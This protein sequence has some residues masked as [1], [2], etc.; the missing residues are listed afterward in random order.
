VNALLLARKIALQNLKRPVTLGLLVGAPLLL[1][2]ILGTAL[3]DVWAADTATLTVDLAYLESGD[4]TLDDAFEAFVRSVSMINAAE[5]DTQETGVRAVEAA[6]YDSL[7]ILD[8]GRIRVLVNDNAGIR[9]G[10]AEALVSGFARRYDLV[11]LLGPDRAAAA[12]S[13]SSTI[14]RSFSPSP[15]PRAIDYF[16]VNIL[17]IVILWGSFVG[18]YGLIGERSAGTLDRMM[19]APVRRISVFAG[20]CLGS[21]GALVLQMAT[22][23]VLGHLGLGIDYG[24]SWWRTGA[25][26]VAEASF[27]LA[28]GVGMASVV[29]DGKA[30]NGLL[31]LTVHVLILLGGGYVA[32]PDTALLRTISRVSPVAWVQEALLDLIHGGDPS[33]FAPALLVCI[34]SA[35]II[36]AGAATLATRRERI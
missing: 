14:V 7:V 23:L 22:V 25:L 32:L 20:V 16:G 35:A 30:V 26:L 1:M 24:D 33:G 6:R 15:R 18:A 12:M 36:L 19:A 3:D 29:R 10:I 34:V 17:V 5:V 9:A 31:N 27:A 21:F 13:E 4:E 8:G 2:V 11:A 28:L